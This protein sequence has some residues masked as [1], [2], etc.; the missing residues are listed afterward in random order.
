MVG[1]LV[2]CL[3]LVGLVYVQVKCHLC[4]GFL[5]VRW[6]MSIGK[7]AETKVTLNVIVTRMINLDQG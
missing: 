1:G 5:H 2:T 4:E 7:R 6:C 3:S